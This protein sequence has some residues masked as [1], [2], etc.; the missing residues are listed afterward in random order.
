MLREKTA[1][2]G[3][4]PVAESIF[5]LQRK[6]AN[7]LCH[8]QNA[9]TTSGS[10]SLLK[11]SSW[12]ARSKEA[13]VWKH[14]KIIF[15]HKADTCFSASLAHVF[16]L[17]TCLRCKGCPEKGALQSLWCIHQQEPSPSPHKYLPIWVKTAKTSEDD[18]VMNAPSF[19]IHC[20]WSF[21]LSICK[22]CKRSFF[23]LGENNFNYVFPVT[24]TWKLSSFQKVELAEFGIE[25]QPETSFTDSYFLFIFS[26]LL[27]LHKVSPFTSLTKTNHQL[28][29]IAA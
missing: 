22:H 5:M 12:K 3:L 11:F 27:Q 19:R 15:V 25:R 14:C 8:Y 7:C 20:M 2:P 29:S 24:E 10:S 18:T 21:F 4:S 9:A 13:V 17:Q 16:L 28:K 6:W 23:S 1:L 26:L